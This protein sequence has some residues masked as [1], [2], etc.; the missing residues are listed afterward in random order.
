VRRWWV[1]KYTRPS[2]DPLFQDRCWVEWQIEM[3]EDLYVRRNELK[4]QMAESDSHVD[5]AKAT[6]ALAAIDALLGE[7]SG[8]TED[9]LVDQWERDLDAG[10][11]PD[12]E[13]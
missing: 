3:Y 13:A 5:H 12:L 8:E 9:A 6:Q 10:I 7:G 4:E 2:N 1:S 11:V